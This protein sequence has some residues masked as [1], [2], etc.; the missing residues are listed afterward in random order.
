MRKTKQQLQD[1][2]AELQRQLNVKTAECDAHENV[3]ATAKR[4]ID[5]MLDVL[6]TELGVQISTPTSTFMDRLNF[7]AKYLV[8]RIEESKTWRKWADNWRRGR[9]QVLDGSNAGVRSD[10][11]A[12]LSSL[13]NARRSLTGHNAFGVSIRN[14]PDNAYRLIMQV[15]NKDL[16]EIIVRQAT[17][18]IIA[19]PQWKVSAQMFGNDVLIYL[20]FDACPD[21]GVAP[22]PADF[23]QALHAMIFDPLIYEVNGNPKPS[24][25]AQPA[26]G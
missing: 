16:A 25:D 11:E 15:T 24:V 6:D 23:L 3:Q 5:H 19:F 8:E 14:D 18:L 22:D 10:I 17:G 9:G 4:V 7:S 21:Q 1:D 26:Q 2:V 20:E 13:R 12:E